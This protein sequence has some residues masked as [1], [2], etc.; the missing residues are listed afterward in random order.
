MKFYLTS[1]IALFLLGLCILE[2]ES[3]KHALEE[4]SRVQEDLSNDLNYGYTGDS[5]E[6]SF[7]S[8]KENDNLLL[9][10]PLEKSSPSDSTFKPNEALSFF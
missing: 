3:K 6:T 10:L 2:K 4:A 9:K 5:I 1:L 7:V 8:A